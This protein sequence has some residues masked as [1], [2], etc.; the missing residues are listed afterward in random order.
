M[1]T[2][3]LAPYKPNALILPFHHP[4][5]GNRA[6]CLGLFWKIDGIEERDINNSSTKNGLYIELRRSFFVGNAA[7]PVP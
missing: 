3:S 5:S 2:S 7:C 4:D 1:L 6:L